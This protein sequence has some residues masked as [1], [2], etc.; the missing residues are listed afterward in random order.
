MGISHLLLASRAYLYKIQK[1]L[2]VICSY[3][4]DYWLLCVFL[5]SYV[6]YYH[7]PPG[8]L[9]VQERWQQCHCPLILLDINKA[10]P[11]Q[12]MD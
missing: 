10:W 12:Q 7:Q 3:I 11:T 4:M 2:L 8:L 5:L 9:D 6:N 1:W